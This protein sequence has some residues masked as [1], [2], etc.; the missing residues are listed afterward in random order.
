MSESQLSEDSTQPDDLGIIL[1]W[2]G[3]PASGYSDD[4]GKEQK[5]TQDSAIIIEQERQKI[6]KAVGLEDSDK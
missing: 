4:L 2:V 6:I 5:R 1:E 3:L